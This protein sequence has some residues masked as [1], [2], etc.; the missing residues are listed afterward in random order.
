MATSVPAP[1]SIPELEHQTMAAAA[2]SSSHP[3]SHDI[4]P[5]NADSD[6]DGDLRNSDASGWQSESSGE[7]IER[8]DD[9]HL[10]ADKGFATFS[11][12]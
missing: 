12:S 10:D 3:A 2:T 7:G 9:V 4:P 1:Q 6:D 11:T 8:M 5:A